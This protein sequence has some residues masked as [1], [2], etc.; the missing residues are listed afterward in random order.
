M[1]NDLINMQIDKDLIQSCVEKQI[2]QAIVRELGDC[3]K[4]MEELV[5]LALMHKVDD[6]GNPTTST[7]YKDNYLD[8][9]F[10]TTLRE[11]AKKAFVE[12][13]NSKSKDF[14]KQFKA[15]FKREDVRE[16]VMNA[17]LNF[18]LK[19]L[20]GYRTNI[21]ISVSKGPYVN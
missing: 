10:K 8:Y 7:Y 17:Y 18:G 15:F 2:Q 14:E 13:L 6:K 11:A 4:Y 19:Q 9:L 5:S 16:K 12:Y 21:D 3:N 20:N 1:N